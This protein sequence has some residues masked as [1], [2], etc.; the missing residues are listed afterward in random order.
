M[1][2]MLFIYNPR[3]GKGVVRDQL[4]YILE[5]FSRDDYE[6]V[7]HPTVEPKDATRITQEFGDAFDLIVC[8]GGDG[9]L[10]EVVTGMQTGRFTRPLG[11]IPAGSTNDYAQSLGIPKQMRKEEKPNGP[12]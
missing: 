1:K 11:Y 9:T 2:R 6:I 8:S 12:R 10:D 5:E 7:V 4:S 3:S